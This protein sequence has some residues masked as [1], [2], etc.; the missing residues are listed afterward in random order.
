MALGLARQRLAIG[1]LVFIAFT[2]LLGFRLIELSLFD[3][4]VQRA[5]P[6]VANPNIR[7]EIVDEDDNK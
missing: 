3:G 1:I 5:R 7:A 2:G 6:A 4:P